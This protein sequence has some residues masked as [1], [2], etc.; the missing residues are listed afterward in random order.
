MRLFVVLAVLGATVYTGFAAL[1]AS[2]QAIREGLSDKAANGLVTPR[3]PARYAGLWD[4]P[5]EACIAK[6][7]GFVKKGCF[8]ELTKKN[9][10]ASPVSIQDQ[11][12]DKYS[13]CLYDCMCDTCDENQIIIK[14]N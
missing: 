9:P 1:A 6:C 3:P 5:N 12:D 2:S 4:K 10:T 14:Q 7:E 11:C 8:A 13:L